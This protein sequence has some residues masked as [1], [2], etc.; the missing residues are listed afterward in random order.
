MSAKNSF[1]LT[2]KQEKF[3]QNVANGKTLAD[4]YRAA[5]PTSKKWADSAL[6]PAASKLM[7]N[8]KV[9]TRVEML[10]A[11]AES[12]A[13][14]SREKLLRE[15]S[16]LAFSDPRRLVNESGAMVPLHELDD[17]TA[18][19]ISSVEVDE[20]GKLK[21]KLWDKGAAQEKL[22]KVLGVY[23]KDNEQKA[24]TVTT[25]RLIPLTPS[26]P[27]PALDEDGDAD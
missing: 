27:L 21:Y 12:A 7:V 14:V 20:C 26:P 1:G 11:K 6:H 5:Y 9:K 23:E 16:R 2:P 4:A 19:A 3:A 15:I 18:A 22:A 25:V 8:T 24:P 13:D 10:R 17:D